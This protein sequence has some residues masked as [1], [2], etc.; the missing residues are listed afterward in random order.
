[1]ERA[2]L[3]VWPAAAEIISAAG[4]RDERFSADRIRRTAR[5]IV[6]AW[7]MAADGDESTLAALAEPAVRR[8]LIAPAMERWRIGPAPR[9]SKIEV[10]VLRADPTASLQLRFWADGEQRFDDPASGTKETEFVGLFDLTTVESGEWPWQLASGSLRTVDQ[11][12]GY[13]FISRPESVAEYQRRTGSTAE[14][15]PAAGPLRRYRLTSGFA[16]HDEKLGATAS[17]EVERDAAP[18]RAQAQELIWPAIDKTVTDLLGEGDWRP[19][20]NWLDAIELLVD[21]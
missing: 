1:M 7:A 19:S 10:R 16:E 4:P 5:L 2:A 18:T 13:V 17:V 9:V 20:M 15:V 12:Y 11:Y 21:P 14:P 3:E 6:A 8:W